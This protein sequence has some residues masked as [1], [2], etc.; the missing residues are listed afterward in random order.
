M[1]TTVLTQFDNDTGVMT[2]T[3]NRPEAR[4]SLT[5][6][7]V[8][9][10]EALFA[11]L[12]TREDVR[13]VLMRSRGGHFCAGADLKGVFVDAAA[14]P[15]PGQP[16]P[17]VAINRRFG[18]LLRAAEAIPQVLITVCEGGGVGRWFWF[19]LCV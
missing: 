19:G 2:I 9:A 18:E 13:V 15:T 3:L 8:D 4:N 10:L 12:K 6:D 7:M 11:E 14:A 17:I 5:P 16:D 1:T